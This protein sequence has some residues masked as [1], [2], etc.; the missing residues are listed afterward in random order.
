MESLALKYRPQ[1]FKEVVGQGN[2]VKILESQLKNNDIKQAYLFKGASGCGK[3][4]C[5]RIFANEVNEY[6]GKPIELNA[7][8]T[9]SVDDIRVIISSLRT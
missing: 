7:A 3:T 9:N 6:K 8:D 5:A 1:K 4:T 2:A